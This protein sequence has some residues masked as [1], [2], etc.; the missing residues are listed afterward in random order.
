MIHFSN[1]SD[2]MMMNKSGMLIVF[3]TMLLAVRADGALAESPQSQPQ[4]QVKKPAATQTLR[5]KPAEKPQATSNRDRVSVSGYGSDPGEDTQERPNPL[6]SKSAQSPIP[7]RDPVRRP[8]QA[9]VR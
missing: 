8:Q 5:A 3:C 4:P 2:E 9:P 7:V 6:D 1:R